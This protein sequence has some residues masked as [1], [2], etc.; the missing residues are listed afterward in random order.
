VTSS[1]CLGDLLVGPIQPPGV[2]LLDHPGTRVAKSECDQDGVRAG[3]EGQR[4]VD[5]AYLI[6][7]TIGIVLVREDES[8][9]VAGYEYT[10]GPPVESVDDS[11][12]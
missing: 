2:V 3:L 10:A 11:R 4:N 8:W 6:H 5:E 12:R 9:K 7:W 1:Q